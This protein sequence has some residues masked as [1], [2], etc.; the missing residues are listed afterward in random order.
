MSFQITALYASLLTVMVIV[1][2][3]VVSA[4]RGRSGIS[5][6]DGGDAD[7]ALWM[8]R[9]GNLVENAPLAL[10]LM[11]FCEAR[12]L[13][14]T[15]LHAIGIVLIA[16]RALHLVGLDAKRVTSPLRIAGGVG[17]QLAM[18]GAAAYLLWPH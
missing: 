16:S 13:G 15:W 5:I 3:N 1:L 4:K 11:A 10:L 7:L 18:L 8:R 6:L 9:H 2:A 14:P 17:T 12:G